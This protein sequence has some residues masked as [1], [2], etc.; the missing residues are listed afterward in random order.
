MREKERA[1][2]KESC[3]RVSPVSDHWALPRLAASTRTT[4]RCR[5][6]AHP[7]SKSLARAS[8]YTNNEHYACP[9][10]YLD[11]ALSAQL[12]PD[13]VP[14]PNSLTLATDPTR[15]FCCIM[16]PSPMLDW[17]RYYRA[18][19]PLLQ[20]LLL[21]AWHWLRSCGAVIES[22]AATSSSA[23][24]DK[25]VYRVPLLIQAIAVALLAVHRA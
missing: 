17:S 22:P 5:P 19:S 11:P 4:P 25:S 14:A 23:L 18:W 21:P 3:S 7:A 10:G 13:Q 1:K 2:E 8:P 12:A 6:A 24:L 9:S 16:K 20:Y 15:C